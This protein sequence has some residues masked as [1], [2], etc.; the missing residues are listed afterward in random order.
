MCA[1]IGRA[2]FL[3]PMT[4]ERYKRR[5]TVILSAD[6]A[7]YSRLMGEDEDATVRTL[8]R[9]R[10]LFST[11]IQQYNG[12]V[13]DA[14]G[15]NLLAQFASVVDAVQCAVDT[16]KKIKTHNNPLPENRRMMFRIG[17]NIGD[18]IQDKERIY[19]DGVNLAARLEGL[20][21]PGGICISKTVFEHIE[22][23]LPYRFEFAGQHTVKNI[24]RPVAVYQVLA[25]D[26]KSSP[27]T[28]ADKK[29][30]AF[31][32]TAIIAGATVLLALILVVGI[33]QFSD[34]QPKE[35][36][37]ASHLN[38]T[39][40]SDKPTIA[41]LPF[42]NMSDAPEQEYFSDGMTEEIITRLSMTPGIAVIA[43]NST[44]FYKGKNVKIQQIA[45]ELKAKY[46]VEG[47]V[48]RAGNTVR[49]TAQLIDAA[50]QSH[51]WAQTF[52]REFKDV[53]NLQ[54]EIAQQIVAALSVKSSEAEQARAW[55]VPT[56]NLTAYDTLLRGLS[57]FLRFTPLENTKAKAAFERAVELD[58][59]Y[60]SA[61]VL[62]GYTHLMAYVFG[63]DKDPDLLDKIA[64]LA[65]K[66]LVLDDSSFSAHALLADVYRT[67]GQFEQAITQAEMAISLNPNDPSVHRSMGITL[68]SVGR[69]EEAVAAI[70]KAM[71]LDPRSA[72]YYNT[73][74]AG[75]YRNLG[76]Y[77]QAVASS[78]EALSIN[79]NWVPADFELSMNYCLMWGVKQSQEPAILDRAF[80]IS[81]RLAA[82]EN[83][84]VYGLFVLSLVHLYQ[85]QYEAALADA[86]Q[87]IA[88][89]PGNAD[90]YALLAS[91]LN[92][93]GNP[94]Q[95]IELIEKA[96][97]LNPEPPAWYYAT[98]AT[99]YT[100][101]DRKTE[102]GT[103]YKQVFAR[104]PS[105]ADTIGARLEL[106]LLYAGSGR[107]E[108]A[109]SEAEEVLKYLPHF[110]VA[111]WGERNPNKNRSQIEQGM[112]VLRTVGLK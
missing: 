46:I 86:E 8:T 65:R 16:Q 75:A 48:R 63:L 84:A 66:T 15:D 100:L 92:T 91:I 38:T 30:A 101:T 88:L 50:T 14:T 24:A 105:F 25:N 111:V 7:G 96:T 27:I 109:R 29:P 4:Q 76:L 17:I 106:T 112:A 104:N 89:N 103:T 58:P 19:G 68:N 1:S 73:D 37:V 94:E 36:P 28:P 108:D 44:F 5:L 74:L 59:E 35:I 90:S 72:A 61:Y 67:K 26:Q 10:D 85:R 31:N 77:E 81:T 70:Q 20:A 51:L 42:D 49:V 98:R 87:L 13:V 54:D 83:A 23:K 110:S 99:A 11:L 64:N 69:S 45:R 82:N 9:C 53:F 55:R 3:P 62:L 21:E 95:A 47:S 71:R 6:V 41:V 97:H 60:A 34:R 22:G 79:P 57:H 80:E 33:V 93:V 78:K 12:S 102:A 32:Q 52:D 40:V 2:N 43:R 107:I 39:P 56:A 18:V